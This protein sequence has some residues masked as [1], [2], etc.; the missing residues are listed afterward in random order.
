MRGKKALSYPAQKADILSYQPGTPRHASCQAGA[1]TRTHTHTHTFPSRAGYLHGSRIVHRRQLL[2]Q[3]GNPLTLVGCTWIGTCDF[4]M[5]MDVCRF[6]KTHPKKTV[7]S[8]QFHG[9]QT[10]CSETFNMVVVTLSS[11]ESPFR[12]QG[13]PNPQAP[14]PPNGLASRCPSK[15]R[16]GSSCTACAVSARLPLS[17]SGSSLGPGFSSPRQEVG[18]GAA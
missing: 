9:S 10:G 15:P 17:S 8:I 6:V 3:H 5:S 18:G 12:N 7:I 14:P 16:S 2:Y 4:L 11:K 1:H 13:G